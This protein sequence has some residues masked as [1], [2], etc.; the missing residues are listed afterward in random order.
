MNDNFVSLQKVQ[1][2]FSHPEGRLA[3][4]A[5]RFGAQEESHAGRVTKRID[6]S[7]NQKRNDYLTKRNAT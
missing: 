4:S 5:A 1:R 7:E 3:G 6:V 2:D